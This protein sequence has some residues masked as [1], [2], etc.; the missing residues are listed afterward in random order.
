MQPAARPT[1]RL[2]GDGINR[3]YNQLLRNN[4]V[5]SARVPPPLRYAVRAALG[6]VLIRD[7][8]ALP[9]L[10]PDADRYARPFA[11]AS[12][13]FESLLTPYTREIAWPV[14]RVFNG[15][16]DTVD[17]YLYYAVLRTVRPSR[18]IE[19]GTGNSAW[20]AADA[21]RR[22]GRGSILAIDPRPM[23]RPP[24]GVEWLAAKVEDVALDRF[25]ALRPG[26]VLF[27]DSSHRQD[28]VRYH[29]ERILPRLP[30]GV[31]V[32]VHDFYFPFDSAYAVDPRRFEETQA[33][34]ELIAAPDPDYRV[35][36]CAPFVRHE[37]PDLLTRLVPPYARTSHRVPGSLWVEKT[38][39]AVQPS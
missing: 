18:V 35:L 37:R 39:D 15:L 21:L 12:G 25:D 26:D 33:W 23:V 8:D 2:V 27:I 24:R 16:F 13:M 19:I 5:P 14:G 22:N 10:R 34:L 20:F 32:H 30:K 28:E 11:G 29:R 9:S 3:I 6:D 36:T 38:A 31:I 7:A 17:A 4:L 1:V